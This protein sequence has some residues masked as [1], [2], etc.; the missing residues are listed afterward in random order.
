MGDIRDAIANN[1]AKLLE[2]SSHGIKGSLGAFCAKS[3]HDIASKLE[4]MGRENNL[5]HVKEIY[6]TLENEVNK[7]VSKLEMSI[8]ER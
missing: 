4:M 7:L 3:S 6:D 1:D 5:N 2:R 8:K